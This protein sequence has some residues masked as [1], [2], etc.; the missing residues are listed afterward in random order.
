MLRRKINQGREAGSR[1]K[2]LKSNRVVREDLAEEVAE[3]VTFEQRP[4][5]GVGGSYRNM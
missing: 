3:E 2:I 5:R 4:E 1:E